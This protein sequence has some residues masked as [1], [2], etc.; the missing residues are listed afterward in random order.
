MGE[1][2]GTPPEEKAKR[3]KENSLKEENFSGLGDKL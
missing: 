2:K 3:S 1:R